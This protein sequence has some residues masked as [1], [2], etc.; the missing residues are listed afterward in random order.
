MFLWCHERTFVFNSISA[1]VVLDVNQI[2]SYSVCPTVSCSP[3]V[4]CTLTLLPRNFER[5]DSLYKYLCVFCWF[6]SFLLMERIKENQKVTP[7]YS[8]EETD[9]LNSLEQWLLESYPAE[10]SGETRGN[11]ADVQHK[12]CWNCWKR[13]LVHDIKETYVFRQRRRKNESVL[14]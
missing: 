1:W 6:I 3:A 11:M 12:P 2:A 4:E 7:R 13:K 5:A 8:D 10:D 9:M 14:Q